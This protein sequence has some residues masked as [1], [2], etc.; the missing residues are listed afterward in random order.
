M[1]EFGDVLIRCP[2]P[3]R[4]HLGAERLGDFI[5]TEVG[6]RVLGDVFENVNTLLEAGIDEEKALMIALG[7]AAVRDDKGKLKRKPIE[8]SSVASVRELEAAGSK[9]KLK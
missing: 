6:Q 5:Q 9:K 8:G 7:A 3:G 4:E 2:M 1:S